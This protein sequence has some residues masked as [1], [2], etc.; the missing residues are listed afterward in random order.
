MEHKRNLALIWLFLGLAA[1]GFNPGGVRAQYAGEEISEQ[2]LID[3]K[4]KDLA[5]GTVADNLDKS[6]KIF[7]DGDSIE[8]VIKIE[9][10]FNSDLENVKVT[11]KLPLYLQLVFFPGTYNKT[12]NSVEWEIDRLAAGES[13][14]FN[15]RGIIRDVPSWVTV[16]N[17][18]LMTNWVTVKSEKSQDSDTAKYY[19]ASKG[20][21]VTGNSD[22]LV[23]SGIILSL[24]LSGLSLRKFVRGY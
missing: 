11:D 22:I 12:L 16:N 24:A 17:P 1:I 4:V 2:V 9:N 23:Q 21:P 5:S 8:F 20:V 18:K 10:D 15:I 7:V 6:Q 14:T 19:V 13:K 3:K